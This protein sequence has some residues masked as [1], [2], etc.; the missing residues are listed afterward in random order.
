[1]PEIKTGG[2][3]C[4][5]YKC[6]DGV[7]RWH[8]YESGRRHTAGATDLD[9]AKRRARGHLEALRAGIPHTRL[10]RAEVDEFFAWKKS[11]E[12]SVLLSDAA[13]QYL[14]SRSGISD[15]YLRTLRADI[16]RF[17]S[18]HT[19][20]KIVEITPSD[21]AGFLD[22]IDAGP[23]R[24]NNV[25]AYLRSWFRWC[26]SRQLLPDETTAVERVDKLKT[27]DARIQVFTPAELRV[28]LAKCGTEWQPAIAIQA[29][30]GIRTEEVSRLRWGSVMIAKKLIEVSSTVAKTSR[31]RLVPIPDNLLEWLPAGKD[32]GDLVAPHEGMEPLIKRLGRAKVKWKK[33]GL[34]HAFGSYRCAILRDVA[35]VAWEMGNSPAVVMAHY[36]EAQELETALDWFN[37]RPSKTA[38]GARS[39]AASNQTLTSSDTIAA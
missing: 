30:C 35:G 12:K 25:R 36:N 26:R 19:G 23:R 11:R 1:M 38:V 9:D 16:E 37:V 39:S 7:Y 20:K 34:R 13:E 27:R 10:P 21:I 15:S 29:F 31:R 28:I 8:Y 5:I 33:N 18:G 14:S 32:A 4:K 2:L 22:K 6:A 24:K 3:S 17:T